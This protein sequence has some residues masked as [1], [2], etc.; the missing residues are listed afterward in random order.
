[1]C[2][3]FAVYSNSY[4][5]ILNSV[6][7]KPVLFLVLINV[8][9][10]AASAYRAHPG[11]LNAHLLHW[12]TNISRWTVH[13]RY[14]YVTTVLQSLVE[15]FETEL[16]R[17]YKVVLCSGVYK[18]RVRCYDV[19]QLSMKFERCLDAEGRQEVKIGVTFFCDI[20]CF[21]PCSCQL[22]HSL[23]RLL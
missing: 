23:G 13:F 17:F 1:M 4:S 9:C 3:Y 21:C 18:P 8:N 12:N 15:V 14:W 10:R 19:N 16:I 5:E 22:H 2:S 7:A 11:F 20:F 6:L